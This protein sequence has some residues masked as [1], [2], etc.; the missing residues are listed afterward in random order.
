VAGNADDGRLLSVDWLQ[1]STP[2]RRHVK[3]VASLVR[4]LLYDHAAQRLLLRPAAEYALLHNE[5]L[6]SDETMLLPRQGMVTLALPKGRGGAI[7][8]QLQFLLPPAQS[9]SAFGIAVRASADSMVAAA[10]AL[11]FNVSA[12]HPVTGVRYA[13]AYG[14]HAQVPP[15]KVL[16]GEALD[17]RILVDRPIVEVFLMGGRA[18]FVA[19]RV[20]FD[21]DAT[22][23]HLFNSGN[24]DV[25][26]A[27]IS[28]H[29]MSCGWAESLPIPSQLTSRRHY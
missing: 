24:A 4:E 14:V 8:I 18:A 3:N 10:V 27:H 21:P 1:I 2:S 20:P 25:T 15:I 9:P 11:S 7:D 13:S 17:V 28:V 6:L 29:G 26:A 19:T 22:S 5:T 23:V 12:P 16:P